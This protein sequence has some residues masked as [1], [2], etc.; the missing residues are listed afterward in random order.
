MSAHDTDRLHLLLSE[1]RTGI[2][3]LEDGVSA[4][5]AYDS[6]A[7]KALHPAGRIRR[8]GDPGN[9]RRQGWGVIAP[10]GSA[11]DEL[12]DAIAPL[13]ARR[14]DQQRADVR[15]Y[16]APPRATLAEATTWKKRHYYS[17]DTLETTVPAYQLILGDLDQVPLAIQQIQ[18]SEGMVGRLAFDDRDSYRAYVEKVIR[19]EENPDSARR[20]DVI[21][22]TVHDGTAATEIGHSS[23]VEPGGALLDQ[24]RERGDVLVDTIHRSG[25]RT[26]SP[27]ELFEIAQTARPSVLFSVSHGEGAPRAGWLSAAEQQKEQ[28]AM[29]FGQGGRLAAE[30]VAGARFLPGGVW[31]M[32]AC[33]GAGTP[34]ES[35]YYHWL[36]TLRAAGKCDRRTVERV[37]TSL[38][39]SG[40]PFIAA[41]PKASLASPEGPLAFIGHIDLAWTYSFLDLDNGQK[42]RP[43]RFMN[44]IQRLL[45]SARV[46]FAFQALH[47]FLH[48][49]HNELTALYD[50]D[51][52]QGFASLGTT[53]SQ[54]GHLW[55]LRQDLGGYILL[56]DPAVQLPVGLSS[57]PVR[58]IP[59]DPP[60]TAS[61]GDAAKSRS[62]DDLEIA[63]GMVLSQRFTPRRVAR[64]CNIDEDELMALVDRYRRGGRRA[65]E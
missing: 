19:W 57:A 50:Q 35:A 9:L 28:G 39:L 17:A 32:L 48:E 60:G 26:P 34:E 62:L 56:G 10:E 59:P 5:A 7:P 6:A 11:G 43:G 49:V 61:R 30:D 42:S 38:S 15:I 22:H 41:L 20:G 18:S 4:E 2:P 13:I 37:M 25:T 63:I 55:M 16:R 53:P 52:A 40:A 8:K 33:F 24:G 54:L 14:R 36:E 1:A 31:F 21:L 23:L 58:P 27:Q 29:S 51:K 47:R 65:L 46:G 12:L 3:A 45:S 44:S 64:E